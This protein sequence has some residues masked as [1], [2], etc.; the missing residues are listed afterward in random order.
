M[1]WLVASASGLLLF[2]TVT[3]QRES[4]ADDEPVPRTSDRRA[5]NDWWSLQPL[6]AVE[7]PKVAET[8]WA[9]NPVDQIGRAHV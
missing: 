2:F 7:P 3:M 9:I 5:G 8:K 6:R 1:K 4:I